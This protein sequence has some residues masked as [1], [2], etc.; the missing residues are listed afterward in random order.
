MNYTLTVSE[1]QLRCINAA[2]EDYF[3]L[4]MGQTWQLADDWCL[5]GYDYYKNPDEGKTINEKT[6]DK[7]LWVCDHVRALLDTAR[8]MAVPPSHTL[9]KLSENARICEDVWQVIRHQLWLDDPDGR[10]RLVDSRPPMPV[11]DEPLC[12]CE[13]VGE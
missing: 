11:A 6:F 4:R 12:K 7:C 2:L 8:R 3:R 5:Q 10:D 1:K 13:K 9:Y